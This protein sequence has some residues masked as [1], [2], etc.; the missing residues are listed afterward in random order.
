[1][2]KT[3][4]PVKNYKVTDLVV[5]KTIDWDKNV[6]YEVG[7]ITNIHYATQLTTKSYDIRTERGTALLYTGV[8]QP[9][10]KQTICGFIKEM[11]IQEQIIL[12][13]ANLDMMDNQ[14]KTKA[15]YY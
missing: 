7:M 13:I 14:V 8:D 1:M 2:A 15:L 5:V 11:V 10:S 6:K 4:K 9:K 12:Q 3:K